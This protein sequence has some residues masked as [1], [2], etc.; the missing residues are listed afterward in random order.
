MRLNRTWLGTGVC[1]SVLTLSLI[2]ISQ[3]YQTTQ[4]SLTH[5]HIPTKTVTTAIGDPNL[6]QTRYNE[7][8]SLNAQ[9]G[10]SNQLL[11]QLVPADSHT[12]LGFQHHVQLD[13]T[14]QKI[15]ATLNGLTNQ[16][17]DLWLATDYDW[18]G[19]LTPSDKLV[20]VGR[21]TASDTD[22]KQE[23]EADL[24][25][26]LKSGFRLG[27]I[28]VA[29][30][31]A[32]KRQDLVLA[33]SP[34]LFQ[35][36]LAQE[37][38][39]DINDPNFRLSQALVS[40]AQADE[41][42]G[43]PDVFNDLVTQGE[44]VFFNESFEGNGRSC[45]TCHPAT[46]NFT[47]DKPF[48]DSLPPNDPLFV[49]EF[50]PALQFGNAANLDVNGNPQRFENPALMRAFGLIVENVDGTGDLENRFTMRSVPH[51]I[52]MSV[53]VQ[54]PPQ[55]L[56]PPDDRTGWSGD[57]APS[58]IIAGIA[59]SGRV[60][61][62]MVG[63]IVQHYPKTPSRSFDG[64]NPDFRAP[65]LAELD[66][67]EAFLFSIG[68]QSELEI[69]AGLPNE[70]VLANPSAEAGKALFRDGSVTTR[71]CQ[72]C[73]SN[74]GAN[75]LSATNPGNRNFNTGVELFLQNRINNPAFTVVGEPRPVD[76]GFGLNPAG[77]FTALIPQ[78][79]SSNENF[80]NNSFNTVSLVE[81]AD[82]PPFF[83][84]NIAATLEDAIR[85]YN[86]DEFSADPTRKIPFTEAQVTDV[87]NFLRVIN[88]IDN[89]E[90][91]V[92]R[93]TQRYLAAVSQTPVPN[94]VLARINGIMLADARD[95][96]EVLNQGGLHNSGGI[97]NNAV[98][99]INLAITQ[100]NQANNT[101]KNVAARQ[102]HIQVATQHLEQAVSIMRL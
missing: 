11:I 52:G 12:Q 34:T 14:N 29:P 88:A 58:G 78:T 57:G 96:I 89:I 7:W 19:D 39:N 25:K 82:T 22:N 13:L 50:I 59:T 101:T 32:Q 100:L 74:A 94:S 17:L 43:F 77:D 68:R 15:S 73:H 40:V 80:G 24:A 61:D 95:A 70:L 56:T 85:F 62:F 38:Q 8:K 5:S 63:A 76:G 71:T 86:S 72:G 46:N 79:G 65:T 10:L 21:F 18:Q 37:V 4:E 31:E 60:R 23:L 2:A 45:G 30:P 35:R 55:D 28:F 20:R 27:Q 3:P 26:L 87:A 51:N 81:A 54:T 91:S 47:I 9:A 98:Q 102:A 53:S 97:N 6:L 1:A 36:L 16:T 44:E 67:L 48:I 92:L 42:T 90:S 75:S 49:A 93:Q 66:A 33:G 69:R 41:A 84:N 83:H 99:Q 64:P